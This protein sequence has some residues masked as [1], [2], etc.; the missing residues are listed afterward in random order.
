MTGALECE[1]P[2]EYVEKL[3]KIKHNGLVSNFMS[4]DDLDDY[5][6]DEDQDQD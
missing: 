6:S 2:K 4:L 3:K 1:L 5:V